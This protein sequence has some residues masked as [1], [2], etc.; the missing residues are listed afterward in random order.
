MAVRAARGRA[1]RRSRTSTRA[2]SRAR[3][4]APAQALVARGLRGLRPQVARH[5]RRSPRAACALRAGVRA[6]STPSARFD[7]GGIAAEE[8]PLCIAG[9]GP[10]GPEEAARVPGLRHALHAGAP[11]RRA[12][13]LL[14]GRLRR[15]LPLRE[16]AVSEPTGPPPVEF[17]RAA[18]PPPAHRVPAGHAGARRRRAAHA[19]TLIER[20]FLAALRATRRSTPLHDGAVLDVPAARGSRSRTDS[21][22]VQPAA[23]S[24]AAT[25]AR[26][27]CTAR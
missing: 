11:A 15:L 2:P 17:T 16:E 22:V 21:Y 13:G 18:V 9:A 24:P 7:V 14:R 27:P 8:S 3:A 25:S 5:R 12:D 1:A 20:M 23:S 4:T 26:W 10:A 19:S 6:P